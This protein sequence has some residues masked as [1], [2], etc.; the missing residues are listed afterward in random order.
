MDSRMMTCLRREVFCGG[1]EIGCG[2]G[3]LLP[4]QRVSEDAQPPHAQA[5][6]DAPTPMQAAE[7]FCGIGSDPAPH[8]HKWSGRDVEQGY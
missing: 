7:G 1:M 6:I 8:K 3:I 5:I 2:T 4:A